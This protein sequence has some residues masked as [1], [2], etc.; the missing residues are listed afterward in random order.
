MFRKIPTEAW[1]GIVLLLSA[2]VAMVL[3]NSV[4]APLQSDFLQSVGTVSFRSLIISMTLAEWVKN[5]LMAVFFFYVGLELKRELMEGALSSVSTA[6]LPLIAALGGVICPALIYLALNHSNGF[7]HG[8][9]IPTATDIAFALG[10]V[11]LLG[12]R[13]PPA[14]K[15]FLLAIAVVDDLIAILV[16]AFFYTDTLHPGW[17]AG[18]AVFYVPMLILGRYR[19]NWHGLYMLLAMPMWVCM[20]M[21]GVNPTIA[22]VLAALAI[23]MRNAEGRSLLI[24]L[25]HSMRPY[26]HYGVMPAFALASAGA[27]VGTGFAAAV[28]HPVSIGIGLGLLL[29]KPIGITL[30]TLLGSLLLKA[31][32]PGSLPSIIG[33][34]FVAGI[35]F[36][37]SLFIGKLAF[38]GGG[39][40]LAVKMGVYGGSL[41]S[42]LIGL[43]ILAFVHREPVRDAD[44]ADIF[45][46]GGDSSHF[47]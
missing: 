32:R 40:E 35:G 26:V 8:W 2:V 1:P 43:G 10:V 24:D 27:A 4:W 5:L 22:G 19:R 36:T 47:R 21:S 33:M 13:V 29:G 28:T 44:E 41:L 30:G 25:E 18:V 37:M 38:H 46:G 11:A 20:Q 31:K 12:S 16:I 3:A 23:P 39:V 42:A 34:G 9:A 17:L 14:M 15:I 6:M 7:Q 45:T